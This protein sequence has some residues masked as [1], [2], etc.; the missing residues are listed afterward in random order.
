MH[1]KAAATSTTLCQCAQKN[2]QNYYSTESSS[3]TSGRWH[4]L[5]AS[6]RTSESYIAFRRQI[7]TLLFTETYTRHVKSWQARKESIRT[8]SLFWIRN[9][10]AQEDTSWNSTPEEADWNWGRT[11]SA[12]EWSHIGTSYRSQLSCMAETMNTSK[13][14]L[15]RCNE[16]GI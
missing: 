11:S 13:N 1:C 7:K 8:V 5:P 3:I 14:R 16:W 9:I 2:L 4:A 12:N 15:D 6:V 10:T